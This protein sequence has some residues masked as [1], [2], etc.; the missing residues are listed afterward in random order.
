MNKTHK[1]LVFTDA[2]GFKVYEN[3]R[4]DLVDDMGHLLP[5]VYEAKVRLFLR[6][7]S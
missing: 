6:Q 3:E 2:D 4:G 7:Q 1:H 5:P